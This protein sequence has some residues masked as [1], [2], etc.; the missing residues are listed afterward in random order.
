MDSLMLCF[1]RSC[2]TASKIVTPFSN[3]PAMYESLRCLKQPLKRKSTHYASPLNSSLWLFPDVSV[4]QEIVQVHGGTVT[5]VPGLTVVLY[6]LPF[7]QAHRRNSLTHEFCCCFC[8]LSHLK[9]LSCHVA[10]D[11][12]ELMLLLPQSIES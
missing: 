10:Q 9:T 3:T 6:T 11:G 7:L 2:Q 8:S 12:P 1:V 5:N 4:P